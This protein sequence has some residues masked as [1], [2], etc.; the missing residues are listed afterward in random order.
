M[1]KPRVFIADDHTL[2]LDGIRK[3]LEPE[4][5]LVGTAQN[6]RELVSS[7]CRLKPDVIL[8]DISMPGL[9]GIEAARRLRKRLPGTKLIFLTMYS[10]ADFIADAFRL[11]ASGY[12]LKSSAASELLE[13]IQKAIQG[14]KYVT[15]LVRIPSSL[16]QSR[17][18]H[19][20]LTSRQRE[21]LQLIAE[22]LIPKEI[23]SR[24]EISV[25][26]VEFHKYSIMEKLGLRTIAELTK[27]AVRHKL[28]EQ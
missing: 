26:T 5:D 16:L 6:G 14:Q 11:G 7:V 25:R 21:V 1:K 4:I 19:E 22:G 27:Y 17:R 3:L 9:N 24:L 12:V 13:A 10:D 2:I 23:A 28:T 15:P 8:L 18:P 20:G